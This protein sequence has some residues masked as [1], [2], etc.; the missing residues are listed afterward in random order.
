MTH[1]H[2]NRHRT[3]YSHAVKPS[4]LRAQQ[5]RAAQR[6]AS[7]PTWDVPDD[8]HEEAPPDGPGARAVRQD[9]EPGD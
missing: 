7:E 1:G 8:A 3:R 5:R 4:D 2:R 6:Q 9:G